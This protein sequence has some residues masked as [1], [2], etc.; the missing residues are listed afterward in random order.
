MKQE[1]AGKEITLDTICLGLRHLKQNHHLVIRLIEDVMSKH[2][3][4]PTK[5]STLRNHQEISW[6]LT[7]D[8]RIG[9]ILGFARNYMNAVDDMALK[10]QIDQLDFPVKTESPILQTRRL[11]SP[12][13]FNSYTR[14][15][16]W[17]GISLGEAIQNTR[18]TKK[19]GAF[20]KDLAQLVVVGLSRGLTS[21]DLIGEL[22]KYRFIEPFIGVAP[23]EWKHWHNR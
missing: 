2:T 20:A 23:K 12:S 5:K 7:A 21:E 10:A 13:V 8:D 3:P 4:V 16:L 22:H 15:Y 1:L 18:T 6:D 11:I 9:N 14:K 19:I 17:D